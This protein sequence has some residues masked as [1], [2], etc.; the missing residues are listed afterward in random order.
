[1]KTWFLF[2]KSSKRCFKL[3]Q[4]LNS[5][6]NLCTHK[7]FSIYCDNVTN[8]KNKN[9][10]Y[11][12]GDSAATGNYFC[13]RDAAVLDNLRT[14]IGPAVSLPD[15]D[16][17]FSTHSVQ[18]SK[19]MGLSATAAK[20]YLFPNLH[21]ASLISLPQLCDNGCQYLLTGEGLHV[22]QDEVIVDPNHRGTQVL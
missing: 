14:G 15:N 18:L 22:L 10:V 5:K 12:K 4:P 19:S 2:N 21:S 11:A 8:L 3:I 6:N 17:I 9:F 1:M 20:T 7:L 16:V 13:F